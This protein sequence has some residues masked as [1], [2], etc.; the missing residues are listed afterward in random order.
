MSV[1]KERRWSGCHTWDSF[2]FGAVITVELNSDK[3]EASF[4][5]GKYGMAIDELVVEVRF[6]ESRVPC[7]MSRS[8]YLSITRL[9]CASVSERGRHQR[10]Q[11][12]DKSLLR[13]DWPIGAL[14]Y[15]V[16][17]RVVIRFPTSYHLITS[18][19]KNISTLSYNRQIPR[20]HCVSENQILQYETI[21]HLQLVVNTSPS[22]EDKTNSNIV[23][24]F[25]PFLY[26]NNP[27]KQCRK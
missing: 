8:F 13:T 4:F 19:N 16:C 23:F 20:Q 9:S 21:S 6:V 5:E 15:V 11:E 10:H 26:Y 18:V 1:W 7:S 17:I 12:C 2:T 14:A 22:S 24:C 3:R 25:R 27:E